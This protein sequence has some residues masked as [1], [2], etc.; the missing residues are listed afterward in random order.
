MKIAN[1]DKEILDIFWTTWG[2]SIKF[3]GKMWLMIILKVLKNQGFCHLF[4]KYC[5]RKTIDGVKLT[6]LSRFR[7]NGW[8]YTTDFLSVFRMWWGVIQVLIC[9]CRFYMQVCGEFIF[10]KIHFIM[11]KS[12]L[13]FTGLI[14]KAQIGMKL[15]KFFHK[16]FK[17][18]FSM[19]P[20]QK[21]IVNIAKP[22]ERDVLLCPKK[23]FFYLI[24]K[25]TNISWCKS[26]VFLRAFN[27]VWNG[28]LGSNPPHQQ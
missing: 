11:L 2:I 14:C 5:F 28:I 23:F 4:R 21:N 6:P 22:H 10:E 8:L 16:V 24:H 18:I 17:L 26:S 1:I 19:N 25:Q 12:D 7:V 27:L 9:I 13:F 15:V 3:L 20:Y